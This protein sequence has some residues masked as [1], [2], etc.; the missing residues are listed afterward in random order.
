M[1]DGSLV[2]KKVIVE[3]VNWPIASASYT[4]EGFSEGGYWLR[5][6][7]GVQRHILKEYVTDIRPVADDV[8]EGNY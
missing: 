4:Y 6:S 2:G 7:D 3:F 5:R 1:A 8:P